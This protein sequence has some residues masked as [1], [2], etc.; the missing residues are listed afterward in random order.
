M[1]P[2]YIFLLH[3]VLIIYAFIRY[4]K[5]GIGEGL[6]AIAF[7]GIIFAVGW[8]IATILTNLLFSFDWFEKWYWQHLDSWILLR[9]RKEF[10]RD[11]I[12]LL[13]LTGI[14]IVFYYYFFIDQGKKQIE[15]DTS[16]QDSSI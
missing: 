14:E 5:E 8:T 2:A 12:S 1:V 13:I 10:S 9:I 4:K 15:K 3:L 11:T 16:S 7:I 6:L